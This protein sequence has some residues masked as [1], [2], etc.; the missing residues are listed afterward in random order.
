MQEHHKSKQG[1]VMHVAHGSSSKV[2]VVT[3]GEKRKYVTKKGNTKTDKNKAKKPKANKPCWSCGQGGHWSK[4]CRVRKDKKA[5]VVAQANIILGLA[6]TCGPVANMV[7]GEVVVSEAND[8]YV[9]YDP[10]LLSTCL[11]HEWL[12]DT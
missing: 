2:N 8:R 9:T 4:D 6:T 10:V 11:S 12:I 5:R 3:V 1:H 7:V